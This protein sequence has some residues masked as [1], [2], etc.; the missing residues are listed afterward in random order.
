M[1][2]DELIRE[3]F[4]LGL[5][6]SEII[7]CLEELH[8]YSVGLRTLKRITKKLRLFRRKF[9]SDILEIALFLLQQCNEH[10]K[11]HGYRWIHLKCLERGFVVDQETVRV[12][13]LIIDPAGV[14]YRKRR[15][16]RRRVYSIRGPN[17]VWHIDG[18]DK[19]SR[20]GIPIHGC[21]DGFSRQ[22]IWLKA[23]VSNKNPFVI[24][25]YYIHSIRKYGICPRR[26]RADMGT[27]N[28]HVETIQKFL[29]RNHVDE[30]AGERSFLYGKSINNQRIESMWGM[31]R[32]QG[33]Q[34]WINFFQ[35]LV[36]GGYHDGDHLDKELCRFCFLQAVQNTLDD[37]SSIWNRHRIRPYRQGISRCGRP[38]LLHHM[39]RAYGSADF[40]TEI[41][42]MEVDI[43]EGELE[44]IPHYPC[45]KLIEELCTCIM[46]ENNI[47]MPKDSESLRD[48]Y[49]FLR[50]DIRE[51]L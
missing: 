8:G 29:R 41:N 9:K 34:F 36:E 43:C 48:L 51:N 40:G 42:V 30:Y 17:S 49:I 38:F 6:Y 14:A 22:I 2:R 44:T 37:I 20:Y 16:L 21:V 27:E 1:E 25:H 35:D 26:V 45:S 4:K 12:M 28:I 15:R 7:Q 11:M 33:I 32:R 23:G 46:D 31:I 18:Y 5:K 24:A 3:Y 10:G 50:E 47:T 39:P 13:L 19:L